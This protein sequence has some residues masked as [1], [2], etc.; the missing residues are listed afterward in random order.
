MQIINDKQT[1]VPHYL[2]CVAF[3]AQDTRMC[4]V[5]YC[6][7]NNDGLTDAEILMQFGVDLK[8]I[9][10]IG[11]HW[12]LE[13]QWLGGCQSQI[14]TTKERLKLLQKYDYQVLC[15]CEC[16]QEQYF[17]SIDDFL[18]NSW[19]DEINDGTYCYNCYQK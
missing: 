13:I 2:N 16:N 10:V 19:Y 4:G 6:Q 3:L 9:K 1:N 17:D 5:C 8:L 7:Y 12:N 14:Y 18:Q 11:N 15:C